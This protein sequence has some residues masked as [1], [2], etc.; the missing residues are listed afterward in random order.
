M[1]FPLIFSRGDEIVRGAPISSVDN[2]KTKKWR[3]GRQTRN[4]Q[5]RFLKNFISF[6]WKV[7]WK[8]KRNSNFCNSIWSDG[9]VWWSDFVS[10]S[11][12]EFHSQT[13]DTQ[14]VEPFPPCLFSMRTT[15]TQLTISSKCL[16]SVNYPKFVKVPSTFLKINF[17]LG[18]IIYYGLVLKLF[19]YN[20]DLPEFRI[21][22]QFA[23]HVGQ[24]DRRNSLQSFTDGCLDSARKLNL[25]LGLRF[26]K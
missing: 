5:T 19:Y 10:V 17:N 6:F 23:C 21:A 24:D 13:P 14:S 20:W 1:N 7:C 15:F 16:I 4:N 8:E 11:V 9:Q 2:Q 12:M 26:L 22:Q 25:F 18:E 3:P